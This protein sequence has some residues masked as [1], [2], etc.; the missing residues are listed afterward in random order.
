MLVKRHRN[1]P[2]SYYTHDKS[3]CSDDVLF[4]GKNKYPQK[5]LMWLAQ[6]Q[7]EE[8]PYLIFDHLS[9]WQ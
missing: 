5:I 3:K 6:N 9:Q 2:K 8:C 4:I 7:I 1:T